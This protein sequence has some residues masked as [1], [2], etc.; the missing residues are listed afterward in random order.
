M[1]ERFFFDQPFLY[2]DINKKR[3][4]EIIKNVIKSSDPKEVQLAK[5]SVIKRCG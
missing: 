4:L 5:K 3:V 1:P 2:N